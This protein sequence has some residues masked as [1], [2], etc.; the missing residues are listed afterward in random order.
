MR[1]F[2]S[3]F[4]IALLL[5]VLALWPMEAEPAQ[6]IGDGTKGNPAVG[7]AP[8]YGLGGDGFVLVKNWDFGGNGTIKCIDDLSTNFQYHD[9]FN[10]IGN[11]THYG[12]VTVSP[13]AASSVNDQQPI[14][15]PARPVRLFTGNSLKTFLVP[16]DGATTITPTKHNVGCGSFQA[17]WKL[18]KGG[19]LLGQ[20]LIWE[21][22]V[23][24]VVPPYFWFAI[25]TAGNKW[26][27]GAEMDLVESFGYDNGKD[28]KGVPITNY[29]GDYWHS[30]CVGGVD[31]SDYKDWG[32]TMQAYGVKSFDASQY[33]IW[34][35]IYKKDDTYEAY[36]DGTL[37]QSGTLV[38]T[39][40]G[41]KDGEPL[42]MDFIF[43]GTW[44]HTGIKS[45]N[46]SLPASA[47]EGK[48]YEWD[49]SR[50]YLR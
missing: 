7:P 13:D 19:S 23:R 34:T 40:G 16:L 35:W 36:V 28:D 30:G 49:Y 1:F 46:Y 37:V 25:W 17:R 32:A 20:D 21:T 3:L 29:T 9:Q 41:K 45:V 50:V 26:N 31:K 47:L 8:A 2:S 22:R 43:D 18:P 39:L 14:E 42:D 11:G 12:A 38:W 33:H 6:T 48:F 5:L 24:Y 10:T 44:G 4:K 27:H 15:D